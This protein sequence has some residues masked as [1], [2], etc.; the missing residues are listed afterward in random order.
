V[1]VIVIMVMPMMWRGRPARVVRSMGHTAGGRQIAFVMVVVIVLMRMLM[2]MSVVFMLMRML[3]LRHRLAGD[4]D[5]KLR[6][7]DS[8][9]PDGFAGDREFVQPQVR[10]L[11]LKLSEVSP[12]VEKGADDHVTRRPGETVKI[13]Y[14]HHV[15]S[16]PAEGFRTQLTPHRPRATTRSPQQATRVPGK[17]FIQS[18][19]GFPGFFD[20]AIAC[21]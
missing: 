6:P 17:I 15:T 3:M 20:R 11:G 2:V 10:K 1:G 4:D 9:S 7:A 14:T 5:M 16:L 12:G 21:T 8:A 19:T 13:R 18:H